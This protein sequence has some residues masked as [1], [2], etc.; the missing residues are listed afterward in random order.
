MWIYNPTEKELSIYNQWNGATA[1]KV[2]PNTWTK[3]ELDITG[4]AN[5][6]TLQF[7]SVLNSDNSNGITFYIDDI[8]FEK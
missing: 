5:Y 4:I 7:V 6:A 3:V 8:V 1:F 2:K